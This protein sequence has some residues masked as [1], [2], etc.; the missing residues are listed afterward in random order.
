LDFELLQGEDDSA[1]VTEAV[2][3]GRRQLSEY[4]SKR[5]LSEYGA[6]VTAFEMAEN[7]DEAVKAAKEFADNIAMK[8]ASPDITHKTEAGG[9]ALDIDANDEE[10]VRET[11]NELVSN[12]QAYD[13]NADIEG[14]LISPMADEGTELIIGIVQDPEVGP[15]IM[16]GLGGV[17]VEVLE[18]VAF[19]AL[20]LS[21][22]DAQEII[23]EIDATEIVNGTR[24]NPPLDRESIADLLCDISELAVANPSISELDL[25]P[26]FVYENG[27][28]IVDASIR[29]KD[30]S[31]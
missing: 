7:A 29:L 16:F 10:I 6:P 18:D 17:F 23:D 5:V 9:V 4:S 14:V 28:E 22:H 30:N 25:N 11:F 20:P 3:T 31:L 24:D 13:S 8:I 26:V 19:R 2:D 27:V 15:M 21:E 1:F 12:A